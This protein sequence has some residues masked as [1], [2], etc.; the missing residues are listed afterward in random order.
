LKYE[1]IIVQNLLLLMPAELR[2]KPIPYKLVWPAFSLDNI[3]ALQSYNSHP[4]SHLSTI[5]Q[6]G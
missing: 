4:F 6:S 2:F 1:I 5:W 3:R